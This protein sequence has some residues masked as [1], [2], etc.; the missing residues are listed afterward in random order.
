MGEPGAARESF[1]EEILLQLNL[2]NQKRGCN[3]GQIWICLEESLSFVNE[4]LHLH[5]TENSNSSHLRKT[6]VDIFS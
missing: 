3:D 6:E 5:V 4:Y 1:R 2:E